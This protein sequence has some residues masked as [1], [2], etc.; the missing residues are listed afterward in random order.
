MCD[1]KSKL[2]YY[3]V[4]EE[5]FNYA[6]LGW[7]F[8]VGYEVYKALLPYCKEEERSKKRMMPE[9]KLN[10]V[11][12]YVDQNLK[13][14]EMKYKLKNATLNTEPWSNTVDLSK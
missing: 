3:K 5:L 1:N 10:N 8:I 4:I 7:T 6:D 12:V 2:I 11:T 9:F 14:W 13:I